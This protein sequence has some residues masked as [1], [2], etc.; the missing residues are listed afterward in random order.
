MKSRF[1]DSVDEVLSAH[2]DG[3]RSLC[4][5]R[6]SDAR[7]VW[8]VDNQTWFADEP[9]VL[10]FDD[11][12]LEIVFG[13]TNE[14]SLTWDSIDFSQPPNWF[15]CYADMNLEWRACKNSAVTAVIGRR[16][17]DITL[18]ENYHTEEVI[19]DRQNSTNVGKRHS[20]WL[21]HAICFHFDSAILT[22]FNAL[23]EN[24]LSN[25]SLDGAKLRH[26]S[27]GAA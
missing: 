22:V 25:E 16:L 8:D 3:L 14:L 23:D 4:G 21:L 17:V 19:A 11:A 1:L 7:I 10:T 2:G 6:L 15:G 9:V 24:G 27:P 20:A 13:K 5:Q 18:V 26:I 12:A